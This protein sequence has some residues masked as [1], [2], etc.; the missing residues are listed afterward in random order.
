MSRDKLSQVPLKNMKKGEYYS[1]CCSPPEVS[2][3]TLLLGVFT[4][5]L[6]ERC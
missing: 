3:S 5:Q 2:K 6:F 1:H 4:A